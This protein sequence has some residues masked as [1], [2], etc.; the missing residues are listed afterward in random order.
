MLIIEEVHKEVVYFVFDEIRDYYLALRIMQAHTDEN[1]ID[2]NAILNQIQEIRD[3]KAPCEE[4]II[5][6][7]YVFF[8]TV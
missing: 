5:H 4:G 3:A 1:T 2:G 8:R 7:T 6:Y